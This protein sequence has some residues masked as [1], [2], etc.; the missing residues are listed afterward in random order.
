MEAKRESEEW[1]SEYEGLVRGIALKLQ[2]EL[3]WQE[4]LDD[5]IGWGFQGLL[6]ARQRYDPSR[7]VQFTTF[8]HYRIRGAILDGL[9][10]ARRLPKGLEQA[11]R[12]ASA[13]NDLLENEA[14]KGVGSPLVPMELEDALEAM[15][16]ILD[17]IGV[18]FVT[19]ALA[20][21]ESEAD[22][23]E[24]LL[25]QADEALRLRQAIEQLP[26]RERS[27]IEGFYFE[28]RPLEEVARRLGVSK[29]WASRI[30]GRALE[31]LKEQLEGASEGAKQGGP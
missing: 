12:F 17:G 24:N 1:I 31:M 4:E 10:Q 26:E 20:H 15:R 30:H 9:R 29:S 22:L 23:P 21:G 2:A 16:A 28:D 5:L 7:G 6:E 25:I 8:A 27:V 19:S 11:V 18:A 13:A 14:V 3:G